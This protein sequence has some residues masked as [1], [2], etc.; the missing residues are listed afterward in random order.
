MYTRK[1]L[2]W[3]E[4]FRINVKYNVLQWKRF[5]ANP[6]VVANRVDTFLRKLVQFSRIVYDMLLF[7]CLNIYQF[8]FTRVFF[9]THAPRYINRPFS[10]YLKRAYVYCGRFPLLII[11]LPQQRHVACKAIQFTSIYLS[12][13]I[14]EDAH[15][16][17][18]LRR[19]YIP[20]ISSALTYHDKQ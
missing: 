3:I 2:E 20:T 11:L 16:P 10:I 4:I 17:F 19:D 6:S 15:T 12:R 8:L 14:T 9:I 5:I 18:C 13:K 7:K 1:W